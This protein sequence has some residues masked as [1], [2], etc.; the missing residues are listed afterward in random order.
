MYPAP[1]P[2]FLYYTYFNNHTLIS[3]TYVPS[4]RLVVNQKVVS[5]KNFREK[6]AVNVIE[7]SQPKSVKLTVRE[8]ICRSDVNW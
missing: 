3:N 2:L 5:Q 4:T 8:R 7:C 1:E 6:Y